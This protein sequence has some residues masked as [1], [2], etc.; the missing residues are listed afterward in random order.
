[1][2]LVIFCSLLL[3]LSSVNFDVC[4]I[5]FVMYFLDGVPF[6]IFS[7]I[8]DYCTPLSVDGFHNATTLL[9]F[10]LNIFLQFLLFSLTLSVAVCRR[11]Q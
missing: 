4:L 9:S 3:A 8:R 11:I 2:Q 6:S 7:L 1:M 5:G 10:L